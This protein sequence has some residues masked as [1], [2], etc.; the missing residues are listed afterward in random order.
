MKPHIGRRCK[1]MHYFVEA[2]LFSCCNTQ[3]TTQSDSPSDHKWQQHLT[4]HLP[5]APDGCV[6]LHACSV[7]EVN[8]VAPL[9][10]E[11]IKTHTVHLTVVTR[12][13]MAQAQQLFDGRLTI[14]FLPWDIPGLMQRWV[15]HVK[16]GMLLLTETEFWPGMLNACRRNNIPVIGINTRIS[17][18]SFPRYFAS[19]RL[20]QRWLRPVR[21]F[22]A[23]SQIDAERLQAL[24]I[25]PE[26]IRISGN[27]KFVIDA[28]QVES[29][30]LR[31][32]IDP[33]GRRPVFIAASTHEGE[34]QMII[35]MLQQWRHDAPELLCILIPRHPQRFERVAEYLE[36]QHLAFSRWSALPQEPASIILVDAMGQ[37]QSLFTIADLA[38]IGGSL[39][40][41]GGHNPLEAAI[42]GRG[43]VTGPHIENFRE[44]M[45]AMVRHHAAIIARDAQ[46]LEKV[47]TRLINRPQELH[48]LHANAALFMQD[49]NEILV[50]ICTAIAPWLPKAGRAP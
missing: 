2:G 32:R 21:L 11:L 31:S 25:E 44:I 14:S 38:F 6:W 42:C 1:Q 9:V 34:E 39:T 12:T 50:Q 37:L 4:L 43:V 36:Q 5:T 18:R 47:V 20:W 27:L 40:P 30:Q 45:D 35:A 24:G 23:Q 28:P 3:V 19:R 7:G 49:R 22:L 13:G 17:D 8:S 16:P 15:N 33:T 41:A 29:E 26:R 10:R 46:D 48:Q